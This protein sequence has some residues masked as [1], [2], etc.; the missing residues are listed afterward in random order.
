MSI[1]EDI[2]NLGEEIV[3]SYELRLKAVGEIVGDTHKMLDEFRLNN[4]E[5]FDNVHKMLSGFQADH[6]E[7]SAQLRASLSKG[8]E[9]RISVFKV[10]IGDIENYVAELSKNTAELMKDIQNQHSIRIQG[11]TDLL[12]VFSTDH[13]TMAVN[14]RADLSKGE[15]DRIKD[16][17]TMITNVKS[18][19]KK[20]IRSTAKLMAEIQKDQKGRNKGVANLLKTFANEHKVMADELNKNLAK[21]ETDRLEE[22][23]KMMVDIQKYVEDVVNIT[24]KLMDEIRARQ[25]ERN[26]EVLGL[27]QEFKTDREKMASN[28]K[29]LN[30]T[31][32]RLRSGKTIVEKKVK[33]R[34]VK[35]AIEEEKPE[36]EPEKP[37]EE[38]KPKPKPVKKEEPVEKPTPKPKPAKKEQP[39][40][41]NM[42]IEDKV[43]AFI[44]AHP[45]GVQVGDMEEPL[46]V[47][48]M[49]LG[50]VAKKLLD[51]G[52][53]KKVDKDYFPV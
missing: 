47:I 21:G 25:D 7:M 29:T 44:N 5:L 33:V 23:Q 17:E 11:V 12:N 10:M 22:F 2:K 1:S 30:D 48:R 42:P 18:S 4:Q 40:E 41:K 27:L 45:K 46:G 15:K 3:A 51:A 37:V 19:V 35:E 31:M 9:D 38:P 28:W 32:A 13:E 53:V 6:K 36:P 39:W 49:R 8:E 52:K 34:A 20:I 26:N 24:K 16:Y 14:L 50:V 43:L